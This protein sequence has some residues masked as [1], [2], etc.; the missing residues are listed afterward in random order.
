MTYD[1]TVAC[2]VCDSTP[3]DFVTKKCEHGFVV[4]YGAK[5]S[6]PQIKIDSKVLAKEREMILLI[7]A[8]R[9]IDRDYNGINQ[10]TRQGTY[11]YMDAYVMSFIQF[12]SCCDNTDSYIYKNIC[13]LFYIINYRYL[14]I[15][16]LS[17]AIKK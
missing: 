9:W 4:E 15:K 6:H 1:S 8:F 5:I 7:S 13:I 17:R 16:I 10:K 14:C 3:S 12:I 11:V 2:P